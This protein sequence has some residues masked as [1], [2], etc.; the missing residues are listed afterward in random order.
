MDSRHQ[1]AAKDY[2]DQNWGTGSSDVQATAERGK[3]TDSDL[4]EL[5]MAHGDDASAV[6]KAIV[7]ECLRQFAPATR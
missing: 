3:L 7:A 6:A 5:R 2:I 1:Q 4:Q